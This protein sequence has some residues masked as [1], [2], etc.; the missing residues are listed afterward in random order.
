MV[1]AAMTTLSVGAAIADEII[2]EG[3]AAAISTVFTPIK[4]A[5]E[6][7]TGAKMT[8]TSSNPAKALIS[9]EKNRIDVAALNTFWFEDAIALAKK[10]GVV[11][12]P[13]TLVKTDMGSSHLVVFL[14]KSNPVNHLSKKQLQGI[15]SGR[16]NNWKEVGGEN[17]PIDLYWSEETPIL[18]KIFRKTI[19]DG[20]DISPKAKPAGDHYKLRDIVMNNPNAISINTCG[21][22]TPQIKIPEIPTM[23]IPILAITKGKP[24]PKVNQ[25]LQFYLDEFAIMND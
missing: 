15:F 24:S 25:L 7:K 11:I 2:I 8:I 5:F 20:G 10:E 13:A 6:N 12:D 4:E 9:L 14:H 21:L 1:I 22:A 3:G 18:D 19:L 17:R 16:I 23:D